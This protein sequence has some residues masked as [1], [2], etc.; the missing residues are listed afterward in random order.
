MCETDSQK[1]EP[2]LI[3]QLESARS[4]LEKEARCLTLNSVKH[5]RFQTYYGEGYFKCKQMGRQYFYKGFETS[6]ARDQHSSKHGRPF[7]CPFV[8]CH[9][10]SIGCR[11]AKALT[12]YMSE[13]HPSGNEGLNI[14]PRGKSA[15]NYHLI[16]TGNLYEV[17][18]F[19][20]ETPY[21]DIPLEAKYFLS[22]AI[23]NGHDAVLQKLLQWGDYPG[24]ELLWALDSAVRS[25]QTAMMLTLIAEEKL[26]SAPEDREYGRLLSIAASNGR[27]NASKL[28]IER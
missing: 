25:G 3:T 27:E 8:G 10:A 6:Q 23:K 15:T 5:A 9:F 20:N 18:W 13:F 21:R 24:K 19:L 11:T 1:D 16:K 7:N 28:L 17:D 4:N 12:K 2:Y 14:F 22:T 26:N